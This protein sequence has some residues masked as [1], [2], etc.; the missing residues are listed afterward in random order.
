[1]S[2]GNSAVNSDAGAAANSASSQWLED[3]NFLRKNRGLPVVEAYPA[4][5][6]FK[7]GD[8]RI[9]ENRFVADFPKGTPGRRCKFASIS[10]DVEIPV[11]QR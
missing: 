8:G 2:G 10:V 5:A 1:M 7:F 9:D 6:K 3:R 11:L 4:K